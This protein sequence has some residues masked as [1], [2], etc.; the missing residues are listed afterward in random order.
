MA[1]DAHGRPLPHLPHDHAGLT[2]LKPREKAA[3]MRQRL[4]DL[5]VDAECRR[6]SGTAEHLPPVSD[7][8]MLF[9]SQP[10]FIHL[11]DDYL[12]RVFPRHEVQLARQNLAVVKA[13]RRR[14]EAEQEKR[15]ERDHVRRLE[16]QLAQ[17]SKENEAHENRIYAKKSLVTSG[18]GK[19]RKSFVFSLL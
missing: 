11:W 17:M 9:R 1:S 18:A 19:G 10:S 13:R 16:E 7:F 14:A 5:G 3:L 12:L 2:K 6:L 8:E 4:L 15:A